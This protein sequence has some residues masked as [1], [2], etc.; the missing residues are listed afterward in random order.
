MLVVW[1]CVGIVAGV[2]PKV[3]DAIRGVAYYALLALGTIGYVG[4]MGGVAPRVI[5]IVRVLFILFIR[6]SP[7]SYF[8]SRIKDDDDSH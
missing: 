8:F 5:S 7:L 4:V 6:L 3:R 2:A 1:C